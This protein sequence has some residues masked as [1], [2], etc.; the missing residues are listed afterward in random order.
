EFSR[1]WSSDVCS[2]DLCRSAFLEVLLDAFDLGFELVVVAGADVGL[3]YQT[4]ARG[5]GCHDVDGPLD[6][7]HHLVPL[8]LDVGEHRVGL[9][10]Q[11][12]FAHHAHGLGDR[13]AD[14]AVGVT[15]CWADAEG[16]DHVT[17]LA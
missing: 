7:G 1:D 5:A 14:T 12:G 13:L 11:T 2:S 8:A 17:S 4:D 15:G 3:E 10:R 9:A 6:H 16:N